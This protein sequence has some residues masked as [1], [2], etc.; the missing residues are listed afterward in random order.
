ME[1]RSRLMKTYL[2]RSVIL[3]PGNFVSPSL[4]IASVEVS[5]RFQR[6]G[7][8]KAY[9]GQ[10]EAAVKQLGIGL[11]I[12]NVW[13]EVLY[14]FLPRRN[15][16]REECRSPNFLYPH[17]RLKFYELI[18]GR[19]EVF[20]FQ[21][22]PEIFFSSRMPEA[23]E[24]GAFM[25]FCFDKGVDVDASYKSRA[26][27]REEEAIK[28]QEE[29]LEQLQKIRDTKKA[30]EMKKAKINFEA[31]LEQVAKER[32]AEFEN[33]RRKIYPTRAEFDVPSSVKL[34]QLKEIQVDQFIIETGLPMTLKEDLI[35]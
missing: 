6:R 17:D 9:L 2:R 5:A 20:Q 27:R 33:E 13:N 30:I 35:G 10:I 26:V 15:Y 29:E 3:W 16:V 25:D 32:M 24:I 11:R 21:Y 19:T 34:K 1:I 7:V 28:R 8:L 22:S 23:G 4:D 14:E 12:E 18:K 31:W